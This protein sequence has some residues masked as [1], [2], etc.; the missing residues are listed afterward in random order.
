MYKQRIELNPEDPD[1]Y[2][3]YVG[4]LQD[5]RRWSDAIATHEKRLYAML[6]SSI[7]LELREIEKL[8]DDIVQVEKSEKFIATVMK[9]KAVAK[10][11]KDRLIA[12]SKEGLEGKL[13]LDEAK[14]KIEELEKSVKAKA[15]IA[16]ATVKDLE[17]EQKK[18]IAELY[19][20]IGNVCWNW[21][22][23]T[24]EEFMAAAERDPI[25][26]KG[27]SSLQKSIDILPEYANPYSYM[28]LLWREK[29]K[30]NALKR[31]EFIK[32]NEEYNKKFIQI[33]Q[34]AQ[35]R[36]AYEK[37]LQQIGTEDESGS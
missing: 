20:S 34:R 7:I 16:E 37:E 24:G 14:K 33:Y 10:E 29:I 5:Q 25:L 11:E 12:E 35:K 27:M 8:Q 36:E 28:G 21:S 15:E 9:N 13:P 6:D 32:K 17:E 2:H 3:Y 31:D 23:Q 1:G 18:N 4:F 22:Y 30:V 19:Y 26:E